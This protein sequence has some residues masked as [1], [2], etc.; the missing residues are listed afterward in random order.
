MINSNLKSN[1]IAT[2]SSFIM[3]DLI[4]S[5]CDTNSHAK[6][7]TIEHNIIKNGTLNKSSLKIEKMNKDKKYFLNQIINLNKSCNSRLKSKNKNSSKQ[8]KVKNIKG[9]FTGKLV[10]LNKIYTKDFKN[11]EKFYLESKSFSKKNNI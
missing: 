6:N 3:N 4:S 7:K 5:Y 9:K 11:M 10:K 1:T 8:I 2:D